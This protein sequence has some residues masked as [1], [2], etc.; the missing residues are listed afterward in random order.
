MAVA[1]LWAIARCRLAAAGKSS[2][3]PYV[4][5][6]YLSW[7]RADR[8]VLDTEILAVGVQIDNVDIRGRSRKLFAALVVISRRLHG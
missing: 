5:R 7:Q 3:R 2:P 8:N 4:G 6:S 1:V